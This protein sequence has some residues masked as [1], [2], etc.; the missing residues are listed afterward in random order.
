M[1]KTAGYYQTYVYCQ[2][3][4]TKTT[5]VASTNN[6]RHI[7]KS[8]TSPLL[9]LTKA[10]IS[11]YYLT[12]NSY[13]I[14]SSLV[15]SKLLLCW[16]PFPTNARREVGKQVFHVTY[17]PPPPLFGFSSRSLLLIGQQ[18]G[19]INLRLLTRSNCLDVLLSE[20]IS[21]LG[22]SRVYVA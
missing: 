15:L 7:S 14:W 21:G 16:W 12:D 9:A 19:N 3:N 4:I 10:L 2:C 1:L 17:P 22:L 8:K 18:K 11:F 20:E 13:S 6:E 5:R